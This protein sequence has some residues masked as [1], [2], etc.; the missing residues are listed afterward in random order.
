M[1]VTEFDNSWNDFIERVRMA[2]ER[3]FPR[4]FNED[5]GQ[6]QLYTYVTDVFSDN[7]VVRQG[8]RYFR[9]AMQA[10]E[11]ITFAQRGDWQPVRLSYVQEMTGM[12]ITDILVVTELK[13]AYPDVPIAPGVDYEA[14]VAGDDSPTFVTL[15]IG[16]INAKSGNQRFYDEAFVMELQKQVLAN[17]P[18]GIMGHLSQEERATSFPDEAVHW[19]GA[20]QI[21]ELLWG[22][23][24]VPPGSARSRLQRYK[25]TKKPIATSI[26]AV[27]DGVW[28]KEL[29]AWRMDAKSLKLAQI[30]IAPADRAGIADLA[31]VPHFTREMQSGSTTEEETETVDKLTVIQELTAD[32]A[33]LLPAGVRNAV[34][35]AAEPAPEVAQMAGI[36]E[37]LGLDAK[38][39][40]GAVIQELRQ[41]KVDA[42]AKVV[43]DRITELLTA[44]EGGIKQK[45]VRPVVRELVEA[46]KPQTPAEAEAA[47]KAVLEMESV[48]A[49]LAAKLVETMGPPQGT[50]LQGQ[51]KGGRYFT[52]S[53]EA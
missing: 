34:L 31:A 53:T 22:K 16:K 39:D 4:P 44:E 20:V 25:A 24:Y 17:K 47:Y 40:V 28:D 21:G 37:Q 6:Q 27:A 11:A 29:G 46:R 23:G 51:Q 15:P 10:A 48:K 1:P 33:K 14:L 13:G 8:E 5:G 3:Q 7:V 2:F 12:H 52:I 41:A 36:R 50:P 32:D 38:A 35:S 30:D 19:V 43:S 26:D 42:E 45:T 18:V 9:V 49:L